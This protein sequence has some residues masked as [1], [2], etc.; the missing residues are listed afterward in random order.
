VGAGLGFAPGSVD[1][2]QLRWLPAG[3]R[4]GAVAISKAALVDELGETITCEECEERPAVWYCAHCGVAMCAT[5]A[6]RERRVRT[7][8]GREEEVQGN[9]GH[10][11]VLCLYCHDA[12]RRV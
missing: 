12:R 9:T 3:G 1:R 10:W 2:L 7:D 5:C 6:V 11:E 4:D 8:R